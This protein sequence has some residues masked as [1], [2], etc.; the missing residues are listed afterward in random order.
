[1]NVDKPSQSAFPSHL[2]ESAL[3]SR[4]ASSFYWLHAFLIGLFVLASGSRVQAQEPSTQ[5]FVALEVGKPLEGDLAEAGYKSYRVQLAIGTSAH[6]SVEPKN[7][8]LAIV[9]L[10][11]DGKEILTVGSAYGPQEP[12]S[13][14]VM[15]KETSAYTLKVLAT[16]ESMSGGRYKIQLTDIHPSTAQDEGALQAEKLF[17]QG[18]DLLNKGTAESRKSAI[19]QFAQ[20]RALWEKAGDIRGEGH[21]LDQLGSLENQLGDNQKAI[22]DLEESLGKFRAVAD[23]RGEAMVLNDIGAVRNDLGDNTKALQCLDDALSTRKALEDRRGEAETLQ[24]IGNV[25]ENLSEYAKSLDAY[26]AALS[27][28]K[29]MHD[30][31][32]EAQTLSSIGV[33]YYDLDEDQK[34]LEYYEEALPLQHMLG[35]GWGQSE[36]LNNMGSAYDT[37]GEKERALDSFAKS[38]PLKRATGNRKGEA[39]TLSNM[40]WLE[41]TLSEWQE[42]FDHCTAALEIRHVVGDPQGQAMTLSFMGSLYDAMGERQKALEYLDKALEQ[43]RYAGNREW[44]GLILNNTGVIRYHAGDFREALDYYD[45]ALAIRRSV[46]DRSGEAATLNNMGR[47]R[48]ALGEKVEA[49]G[50]LEQS[51]HVAHDAGSSH[52]EATILGNTG[53][54]YA[55]QGDNQDALACFNKALPIHHRLGDQRAEA[56]I[57]YGIARVDR[58][59]GDFAAALAQIESALTI[60]ESLRTKVTSQQLRASYFSSVQ[61][62]YEFYIDLLMQ[63]DQLDPSEGYSAKALVASERSKARSLLDSLGEARP[64]IREGVD[65]SLVDRERSL[66]HLL[67]GKTERQM[68]LLTGKHT[69]DQAVKSREEIEQLLTEYDAIE[70]E[71]REKSPRFAA[72]TQVTPLTLERIQKEIGDEHTILLEYALGEQ[73]SYVWAVTSASLNTYRLPKRAE[74][75]GAAKRVYGFLKNHPDRQNRDERQGT[76]EYSEAV[77]GLSRMVLNSLMAMNQGERV[78]IVSDGALQYIPFAILSEPN[79]SADEDNGRSSYLPLI[80]NHEIINLPS[81]LTLA[82][83]RRQSQDRQMAPKT[84][85][86]IADPVFDRNDPRVWKLPVATP[87]RQAHRTDDGRLTEQPADS[88]T[89]QRIDRSVAEA[90]FQNGSHIPRLVFSRREAASVL[91]GVPADQKMEALDFEANKVTAMSETLSQYRIVHLATHGLLNSQH[92]ELSGLV[93]SLVDKEGRP[94]DGFLQLP[95]IYNLKLAADLVVLSACETALGKE[96]R[97]EGLLGLTRGFMYAGAPRVVASLWSVDDVATAELM[98]RF[99][100]AMLAQRMPPS[101]ALRRAQIQMWKEKRWSSPYYWGAFVIEGDWN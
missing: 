62:Y 73:R 2:F 65:P 53:W 77:L 16:K 40:C 64:K 23:R 18:Q 69:E 20:A 89:E 13:M 88:L 9:L 25:Y 11:I 57:L 46:G 61:E 19:E 6:I 58:S 51:L 37:L 63:L 85:A 97:G 1:M 41:F 70:A 75:E 21:A 94:R 101:A 67:D 26:N 7:V 39:T 86:V 28:R 78:V 99:Y 60:I 93:L 72:L 34:A 84:V 87:S 24:N 4:F 45:K 74:I 48:E 52:W 50:L 96:V 83:L 15:A 71:I 43:A 92:P 55:G 30:R 68:R 38:L 42:A 44:E 3:R 54:L 32:G 12:V 17:V 35:D 81:A 10:G 79:K 27:I 14:L 76:A 8:D 91:A 47:A 82:A 98:G 5:S 80:I 66:Q 59:L 29:A 31:R 36:T 22:A 90:G 56:S 95:D 49:L 100:R 33:V